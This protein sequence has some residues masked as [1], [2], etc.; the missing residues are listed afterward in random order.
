MNHATRI[1]QI[2]QRCQ[3]YPYP[4]QLTKAI[5]AYLA[6]QGSLSEVEQEWHRAR[7]SQYLHPP[8]FLGVS[9]FSSGPLDDLDV[10]ILDL[11]LISDYLSAFLIEARH[12][13]VLP[14]VVD[15]LA[16]QGLDEQAI[17]RLVAPS[18]SSATDL[19]GVTLLGQLLLTALPEQLD[20]LL[21]AIRWHTTG[22]L[23]LMK[24]LL[25][26][27]PPRVELAWQVVQ[28]MEQEQ[29][30]AG[31]AQT[32]APDWPGELGHCAALLFRTDPNRFT[33][34][35]RHLAAPGSRAHAQARYAA[36]E[37]LLVSDPAHHMDLAAEVVRGPA[38]TGP[39]GW[40]FQCLALQAAYRF[41]P[42]H[43]WPLLEE[44]T[45]SQ[46]PQVGAQA[47]NLLI[48]APPEEARPVLQRCVSRG[49]S[50]T[51]LKAL[52]VLLSQPGWAG[53][54]A[55]ALAQLIHAS[56]RVQ[57]AASTWLAA[58]GEPIVDQVAPFLAH[59]KSTT[60]LSA[61]ETLQRI[62]GPRV[63]AWLSAR[64]DQETTQQIRE[65]ILKTIAIPSAQ[66]A[67]QGSSSP[68]QTLLATAEAMLRYLPRPALVWF[69]PQD[70]PPFRWTTGEPVPASVLGYLL[71][72]QARLKQPG[73]LV[74]PVRQA[75]PLLDRTSTGELALALFRGWV[76]VGAPASKV[77]CLPLLC[78]LGDERLIPLIS[79]KIGD[80]A[81]GQHRPLAAHLIRSLALMECSAAQAELKLLLK[82]FKRGRM[83]R[84]T[85]AALAVTAGV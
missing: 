22:R 58:R 38:L 12:R 84:I 21:A 9:L 81:T 27:Q 17:V 4:E 14:Q 6:G 11:C 5:T 42:A 20:T 62:G 36:L 55:Y 61:V 60:R 40:E 16:R 13:M 10:R 35:V 25:A 33:P 66:P 32:R 77:W 31:S 34:W 30:R 15:H 56:R 73:V 2:A 18:I 63:D 47:L 3:A 41:N 57:R 46:S 76:G 8:A 1:T 52:E 51:A 80:W 50:V 24:L 64:L 85:K 39:W 49:I 83:R 48:T 7:S 67:S 44:A 19:G 72:C 75:L 65:Q 69:L 37:A 79:Q 45:L 68:M 70:A 53:Q 78:A 29:A 26:A 59:S 82:Q 74:K 23:D 71:H 43:F 28:R 54:Q